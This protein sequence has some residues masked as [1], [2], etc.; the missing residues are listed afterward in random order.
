MPALLLTLDLR[1]KLAYGFIALTVKPSSVGLTTAAARTLLAPLEESGGRAD[2]IARRLEAAIR[3]GLLLDGERLPAEPELA[4]RLGVSTVTLREALTVLRGQGLVTTRRGRGGGSFV[5]A[6]AD[7]GAPLQRFGIGELRDLGDQRRAISGAAARLAAERAQPEEIRRLEEQVQRLDSAATAAERRRA[8]AELTLAVAAA[9]Q[10]PRLTDEE[11]RLRSELGDLD[12][13]DEAPAGDRRRLVAAIAARDAALAGRLAEELVAAETERLIRGRLESP[14]TLPGGLEDVAG[15]LDRLFAG[16]EEL[17]G[18]FGALA[19]QR[20]DDLQPL[21]PA[22][23]ALLDEHAELVAGTG[24]VTAPGLLAD[25][26]RW[27]EWWWTGARGTPEPLRV[28]LDPAAPDF[29]DYT[30]TDWWRAREPSMTGPYVDYA[31]T[32][33]YALTLSV[34]VAGFEGRLGVAAADVPLASLETR[35]LPPLAALGRPAALVSAEGRVIASSSPAKLPGQRLE[36][37]G[38]EASPVRSWRLV[39]LSDCG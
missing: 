29:Y 15:E 13:G 19:P 9:S 24:I 18:R 39:E 36:A 23:L 37:A 33:A 26:P 1:W 31:C 27:L 25:A 7:R 14:G 2:L 12:L 5:R 17:G 22:I 30:T 16:L 6:P 20:R 35:L 21:R 8:T 11:A 10:S 3:R 32:N 28:N 34:P 38:G 4:A